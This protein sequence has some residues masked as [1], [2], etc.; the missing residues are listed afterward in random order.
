MFLVSIAKDGRR[1]GRTSFRRSVRFPLWGRVL[2]AGLVGGMAV[3]AA[4]AGRAQEQTSAGPSAGPAIGSHPTR[5]GALV[6]AAGASV[7]LVCWQNG[8][9]VVSQSVVGA[10]QLGTRV[11]ARSLRIGPTEGGTMTMVIDMGHALCVAQ[12]TG[13]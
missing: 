2:V 9:K 3:A 12:P 10:L 8:Q 1:V 13:R 7:S 5:E 11:A 6:A 4:T